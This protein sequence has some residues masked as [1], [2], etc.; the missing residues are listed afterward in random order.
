MLKDIESAKKLEDVDVY[1]DRSGLLRRLERLYD[2]GENL[3]QLN[4]KIIE[5]LKKT[6][7]KSFLIFKDKFNSKPPGGEG[8]KA[9]FDGILNFLMKI[10]KKKMVG[11]N[12]VIFS[13]MF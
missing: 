11:M 10:I 8:Y 3:N 6:F 12:T 9:H 13:S 7:N 5:F 4:I 1:S 2:K